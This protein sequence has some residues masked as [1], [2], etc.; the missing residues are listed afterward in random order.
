MK[1]KVYKIEV[2]TREELLS[3]ILDAAARINGGDEQLRRKHKIFAQELQRASDLMMGFSNVCSE[4]YQMC[5]LCVTNLSF[6]Q[7]IKV[8]IKVTISN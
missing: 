7:Y 5:H 6:K 1:S 4:L 3:R 2:D 8:K